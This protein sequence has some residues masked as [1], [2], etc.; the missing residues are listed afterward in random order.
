VPGSIPPG[1]DWANTRAA[2]A[3]ISRVADR[4]GRLPQTPGSTRPATC[5][6]LGEFHHAAWLHPTAA[7]Q[8]SPGTPGH[9]QEP[10]AAVH[11]HLQSPPPTHPHR[12]PGQ[13]QVGI[14][15]HR[16]LSRETPEPSRQRGP[17][18]A[19]E[20]TIP[21]ARPPVGRGRNHPVSAAPSWPGKIQRTSRLRTPSAR[22][23]SGCDAVTG[24]VHV[25][26]TKHDL[27]AVIHNQTHSR[28][29]SPLVAVKVTGLSPQILVDGSSP[30]RSCVRVSRKADVMEHLLDRLNG[31]I[32]G[33]AA[34]W[35]IQSMTPQQQR[36]PSAKGE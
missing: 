29:S 32:D 16:H 9:L 12:Q 26:P 2:V 18:L 28:R 7:R 17:Q 15:H 21:S 10:G 35:P 24:S 20:E 5:I 11:L 22:G 33:I 4:R 19:G 6:D 34:V 1:G 23:L 25:D 27:G 14:F 36:V 31:A 13:V 3:A 30:A 8:T